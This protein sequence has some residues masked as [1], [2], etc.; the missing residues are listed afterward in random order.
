M[1]EQLMGHSRRTFL[2]RLGATGA[3]L[4]VAT[5]SETARADDATT[6]GRGRSAP[7]VPDRSLHNDE[8]RDYGNVD[9]RYAPASWQTAF[10]F[11]DD[12]HKSLIGSQG[13]LLH[14]YSRDRGIFFFPIVI[15]FTT[16]GMG[17]DKLVS[18]ELEDAAIP[19][20]R[21]ILER[22]KTRIEITTYASNL[23][24]EG[25]VDNVSVVFRPVHAAGEVNVF[26]TVKVRA[27]REPR[28]TADE[29]LGVLRWDS[30]TGP[31][32]M[33]SSRAL[34]GSMEERH[35]GIMRS[36]VLTTFEFGRAN[37]TPGK[38]VSVF[39]RFPQ[40][41]QDLDRLRAGLEEPD[42][43]I[44]H[45]RAFW[46]Q[47]QPYGG[48]VAW[49]IPGTSGSFLV[50][51]ARNIQQAREERNGKLTFQV[52]PTLYRGLWVVD[53]NF[54]LEAA[55]YLGYDEQAQKGLETTWSMQADDGGV[56]AG[57]G[58]AHFKDTAI[59]MFTLVRHAELSQDWSYFRK[60]RPQLLRA[61]EFLVGLRDKAKSDGT[62]NG[63]YGLIAPGFADGGL[64]GIRNEFT[65]TLWSLTGLRAVAEAAEAQGLVSEFAP[66]RK[67]HD[68]L[69]AA[70]RDAA[71]R[72]MRDHPLGFQYLPMLLK[73]D[74]QWNA[75][76]EWERPRPQQAQWA[77]SQAIH[78]GVIFHQDDP[79]VHGHIRLM[80]AC[81]Q[82]DIPAET[83]WL[84]HEG[85]WNYGAGFVAQVYL[86]AGM[87]DWARRTFIGFLNHAAPT[88]CWREEQPLQDSTIGTY[89]GD[90]PHNWASAECIR[91]LR[92]MLAMEDG[93]AL[94]LLPGVTAADLKSSGNWALTGSPTRFGRVGL[95]LEPDARGKWRL[96]FER[97]GG[98]APTSLTIP[99]QLGSLA[100]ES[101]SG[102]GQTQTSVPHMASVD[103][104][105]KSWTAVWS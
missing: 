39:F 30:D 13:E 66:V 60:M 45:T 57:G 73:E 68:E 47:W 11:P 80:Q 34:R 24:E 6:Q 26:P 20:V 46:N 88:Y 56:F 21:T 58:G 7:Q 14:G 103:P 37:A 51:S 50:A 105:A 31:L 42:R 41:G 81:T 4:V 104:E 100:L 101:V 87:R 38:P 82:E 3:G 86:W 12:P 25:R 84:H 32:F 74:E 55:R 27:I 91:Y 43:V 85:L 52:G 90:M 8:S 5:H 72:Q 92:H 69:D 59:A 29:Q 93:R 97:D 79:I 44:A 99:A 40:E 9:F 76:D 89:V 53:G 22:G 70:F 10:G 78:P 48:K 95:S 23:P 83:G 75:D 94:R 18:Q 16:G 54:I 15:E 1:Q 35:H 19:I 65:N 102:A 33:V 61:T 98:P 49:S 64:W 62:I 71:K 17:S 63:K 96:R 2:T 77:L 28:R 36:D 67:F